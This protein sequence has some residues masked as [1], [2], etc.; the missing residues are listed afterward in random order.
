MNKL[1]KTNY[2]EEKLEQY[3]QSYENLHNQ[4][5]DLLRHR[6][7][8]KSERHVD[9]ESGQLSLFDDNFSVDESKPQTED[10]VVTIAEHKRK[11]NKKNTANYPREIVIIP[12][13]EQDKHCAC[14]CDKKVIRYESKELFDY[15]PAVF[16]IIEQRREVVACPK[17]EK[18]IAT[19]PAPLQVLPKIKATESLLANIA[20]SKFHHRQPLYHLEKYIS[21]VGFSRETMARWMI[22]LTKPMQA[23]FNLL[24][25]QVIDYDIASIDATTLQVLREPG[26]KA[27]TKSYVYCIRGGSP[28]QS[29]ICYHYAYQEHKQFVDNLLEGFKGSIHMDADP[30]FELLLAD[31]QVHP[32]FCHAHARRKFEAITKHAKKPGLAAQAIRYYKQLYRIERQA[33]DKKLNSEQRLAL[34]KKDSL[35]IMLEFKAWLEKHL[36]LVVPKSYLYKAIHYCLDR[37]QGFMRFLEDGRIEIDNN[38][39]EQEIKPLVIARK[40]FMFADSMAGATAICRHMSFIRTALLHKLDPYEYYVTVLKRLPYCKTSAD[41][42]QLLPWNIS[43]NQSA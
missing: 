1:M 27:E 35:P 15:Q 42:E 25:D 3:Q 30:F 33:K 34:R 28:K 37:W 7:G 11:K 9:D 19:A 23:L 12:V 14:G 4:L 29:V 36:P 16:R 13:A 10:E 41:Y 26:R 22:M 38:L 24:Q 18:S 8:K 5:Q 32:S 43:P 39:T 40:N 31:P 2:L 20:I 6:F 21:A 17:C